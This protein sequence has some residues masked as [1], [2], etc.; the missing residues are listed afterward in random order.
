MVEAHK[1]GTDAAEARVKPQRDLRQEIVDRMVESL[2][3]GQTPWTATPWENAAAE[4]VSET[5]ENNVNATPEPE[6]NHG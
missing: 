4:S 5:Q 2:E 6:V 3:R 1:Q